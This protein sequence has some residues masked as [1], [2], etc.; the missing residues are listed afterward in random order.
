MKNIYI[1]FTALLLTSL[2][3]QR[4][5]ADEVQIAVDIELPTIEAHPYHRPFVAVWLETEDRRPIQTLAVWYDDAEWLK[6]LR[7]WWRKLGRK[8]HSQSQLDDLSGATR[9]PGRY[10]IVWQG[11][12]EMATVFLNVEAVREEGDRSYQR[13]LIELNKANTYAIDDSHELGNVAVHITPMFI[14]IKPND[15]DSKNWR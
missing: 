1:V 6:D 9:K 8:Q 13:Q 4:V 5:Q 11:R 12:S 10:R 7:Q 3:L 15:A 14:P 2:F